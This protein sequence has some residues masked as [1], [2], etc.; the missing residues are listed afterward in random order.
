MARASRVYY[1]N[2]VYHVSIRGNN[3]QDVL[4]AEADKQSFLVS[5]DKFRCR[6]DF[7][8]YAFCLMDNHAHLIINT[9]GRANISK[10]MHAITLSYSVKFRKRYRYSGYVWQG[11]FK[12]NDGKRGRKGDRTK[13][14]QVKQQ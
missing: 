8:L 12:S 2:A 14:G 4:G 13:R 10:V 1:Q 9:N 11:R 7:K 5:L 6:L 3:R